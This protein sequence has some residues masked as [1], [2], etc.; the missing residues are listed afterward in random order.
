[1]SLDTR[2]LTNDLKRHN[3]PLLGEIEAAVETV[4]STGWEMLGLLSIS[5]AAGLP[6]IEDCAQAH[7]ARLYGR[8]AGSWGHAGCFSFYPTKNL[9][10]LGDAGAVVTSDA[11]LA[12]R[13]RTLRQ[14]GW[15]RKYE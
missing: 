7:G 11:A 6:V 2:L 10:A 13:V 8:T 3:G 9:G 4:L 5:N 15:T 1:M 12:D 14:Y